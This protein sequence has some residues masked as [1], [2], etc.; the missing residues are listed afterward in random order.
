MDKELINQYKILHQLKG[1]YGSGSDSF[2]YL[3]ELLEL[4]N[5]NDI[6]HVLDF[7][8]GKGFLIDKI[9]QSGVKCSGYDPAIEEF[10][11]FPEDIE[12]VDL[13]VSTDVFEHL[14]ED[15]MHEDF[16][17][18]KKANPKFLYFNVATQSA[19]NKLPNGMNCHT[20][21]KNHSWWEDKIKESFQDFKIINKEISPSGA[22][23]VI[24]TLILK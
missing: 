22:P 18:I 14:N 4:I 8:C 16:N 12:D 15:C 21:V 23:S 9:K 3:E 7:G 17:L 13:V 6:K 10:K 1:D 24:F 20:I 5:S 2:K 11:E 19:I